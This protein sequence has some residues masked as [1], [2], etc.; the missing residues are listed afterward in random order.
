MRLQMQLLSKVSLSLALPLKVMTSLRARPPPLLQLQS[1]SLLKRSS[2]MLG[3][4]KL[5]FPLGTMMATLSEERLR[6][7]PR[8][9][10]AEQ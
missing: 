9:I 4:K 6:H 7:L 1:R 2:L 3:E 8:P 5:S 10:K